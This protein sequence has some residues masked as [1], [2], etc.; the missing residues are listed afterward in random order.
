MSRRCGVHEGGNN[1]AG[2]VVVCWGGAV[3]FS[4]RALPCDAG[5]FIILV[6]SCNL[7]GRWRGPFLHLCSVGRKRRGVEAAMVL[8]IVSTIFTSRD[9][10]DY[11]DHYRRCRGILGKSTN[12][13]QSDCECGYE[14]GGL[15]SAVGND[16]PVRRMLRITRIKSLHSRNLLYPSV[17]CMQWTDE[18]S[19][20]HQTT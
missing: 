7:Q 17:K 6:F 20:R 9:A 18:A 14:D 11:A 8:Y 4:M 2:P 5:S 10:E 16:L 1:R 12:C 3:V 15:I 19:E 13:K